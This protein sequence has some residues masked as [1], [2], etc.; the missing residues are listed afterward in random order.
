MLTDKR[1]KNAS[2]PEGKADVHQ[3]GIDPVLARH[4]DRLSSRFGANASFE[5]TAREFHATKKVG[6]S[7][8][9]AKRWME[10][11]E[12]D[13]FPSQEDQQ[14]ARHAWALLA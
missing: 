14:I 10:F 3:T 6:W 1:C 11:V 4:V 9:D 2:C 7:E 5:V 8:H 12:K 13:T